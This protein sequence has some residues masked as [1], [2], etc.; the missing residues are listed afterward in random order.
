MSP[1]SNTDRAAAPNPFLP[2][3][4][5]DAVPVVDFAGMLHGG[6]AEKSRVAKALRDACTKVGFFYLANHGIPQEWIDGTFAEAHRFFALPIDQKMRWHMK[7]SAHYCG[8]VPLLEDRGDL[9]EAF[10]FAAEDARIGQQVLYGDYR[11]DGNIWPDDLPDFRERISRYAD[12][13]RLLIKQLFAAFALALELPENYFAQMTD[14]PV[15]MMRILHYPTQ[16]DPVSEGRVGVRGHT[17]HECFSI[18]CQDDV[19]A[20][21]VRNRRG[22]WI[23]VPPI[24]NSFVVNIGDQMARWTNDLFASTPHR[25]INVSGR[26]R[27]S[28]PFFVGANHDA[29]VEALPSCIGPGNPAK[30]PPILSGEYVSRLIKQGYQSPPPI[31]PSAA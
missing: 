15:S 24:A 1:L 6:A 14:K 21:Q 27:F 19:T 26:E 5:F 30:Y 7:Q 17:D 12:G 4:D 2:V 25:V 16:V 28:I 3:A 22:D 23:A 31:Q 20:L 8:Y 18:L 9:K 10:D 13:L 29:V 11:Q